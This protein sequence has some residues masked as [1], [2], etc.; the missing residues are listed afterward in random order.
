MPD[1]RGADSRAP[2]ADV[3]ALPEELARQSI[4]T[5]AIILPHEAAITAIAHLAKQGHRLERWE[6]WVKFRDGSRA[7]SL[8]YGGSFALSRDPARAADAATVGITRAQT[9]WNRSPEYP[10]ATLYFGLAFD[11]S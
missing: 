9:A 4:S 5:A 8:T 7:K 10:D 3:A 6:G 1:G 2:S 11:L